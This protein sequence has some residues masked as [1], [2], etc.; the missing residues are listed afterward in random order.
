LKIAQIM[1]AA[2][3]VRVER[4]D[5][6]LV[7]I[8]DEEGLSIRLRVAYRDMAELQHEIIK[9]PAFQ[10][11]LSRLKPEG[12]LPQFITKSLTEYALSGG[13][14]HKYLWNALLLVQIAVS[15]AGKDQALLFV[16]RRNWS[17]HLK[18]YAANYGI[19]LMEIG[20]RWVLNV[21]LWVSFRHFLVT[22]GVSNPLY[23]FRGKAPKTGT[24]T[25]PK[26]ATDNYGLFNLER[27]EL[28]SELFFWQ[29]SE[30][31]GEDLLLFFKI[32]RDPLDEHKMEELQKHGIE[33]LALTPRATTLSNAPVFS[34]N[35]RREIKEI[36]KY[37]TKVKMVSPETKWVNEKTFNYKL[38]RAYWRDLFSK[39]NVKL[40]LHW[41]K[42]DSVHMAM[43]DALEEVG[44]ILAIYQRAY[45]S[46]PSPETTISA[47]IE[48]GFSGA[49]AQLEKQNGSRLAYHVTTGYPGDH[50]FPLLRVKAQEIREE[51]QKNGA[52]RILCFLDEN[53]LDDGRWFTGHEFTRMN[54]GF[55]LNKVLENEWLG[56]VIK[57]KNPQNLAHRLGPV[58]EL[59]KA[60]RA[61]GRC[62]LFEGGVIQ[63]AYPPAAAALAS[64]LAIQE[65]LS[66]GTAGLESA[67]AGVPTLLLDLEG[68]HV[69]PLYQLGVG[70]VVFKDWRTLWEACFDHWKQEG[71]IPGLGD[72][73]ALLP[74]F[75]PF[76][77]GR[78][79]ER[80]GN[81]VKWILDGFKA[82]SK[83][84]AVM[85][86]AA[87]RYRRIWGSDKVVEFNKS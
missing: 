9:D 69:S 78:A 63:S 2:I 14:R 1:G 48:F 43:A 8:K 59:L 53:T 77:D 74:E 75:D 55:I 36:G 81:Y 65:C 24:R 41:F 33:P 22:R 52:R 28:F 79:A 87:E 11:Q 29:Q 32:P 82:G 70:K 76:R 86:E 10:Y 46:H 21:N 38:W 73:S 15:K 25:A 66:A 44:G 18:R 23:Y 72:W 47:D 68:W 50:R 56:L 34:F 7:E 16:K 61:T 6:R 58:M 26:V 20:A 60:A 3:G 30:L 35:S 45:E 83:R 42:Y 19:D 64:D 39:H 51:L 13:G 84:E 37:L 12:R 27:P 71:G 40:F 67:L 4:L 62:Y 57:P 17:E 49:L 85:A 54:Y 31:S 5:F 80:M